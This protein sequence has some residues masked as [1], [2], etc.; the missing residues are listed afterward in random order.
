MAD[1]MDSFLLSLR[2]KML[3]IVKL[4]YPE[5]ADI[6]P[7]SDDVLAGLKRDDSEMEL[8]NTWLAMLVVV[9]V[10]IA[11]NFKFVVQYSGCGDCSGLDTTFMS[12]S[13]SCK[14]IP[15][16]EV[17][18]LPPKIRTIIICFELIKVEGRI[19]TIYGSRLSFVFWE[20]W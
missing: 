5:V 8:T 16:N 10:D 14:D 18:E 15:A 11:G 20:N 13:G 12:I 19:V 4:V 17:R 7:L 2:L 6:F 3:L 9:V 1:A